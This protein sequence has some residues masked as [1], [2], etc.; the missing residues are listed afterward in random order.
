MWMLAGAVTVSAW[1]P[2]GANASCMQRIAML[3]ACV[4][5]PES[6]R[7]TATMSDTVV[8]AA[9]VTVKV[10]AYSTC[11]GTLAQVGRGPRM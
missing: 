7:T 9:R 6:L 4:V 2:A 8:L 11:A 1:P 10:E 3:E 5:V